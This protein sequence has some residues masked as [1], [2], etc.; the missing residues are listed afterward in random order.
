MRT[1]MTFEAIE[2]RD[3]R[4]RHPQPTGQDSLG[5]ARLEEIV[6]RLRLDLTGLRV[7]TEAATG[8]YS[9][10]ACI[11][12]FAGAETWG[13]ARD[14]IYGSARDAYRQVEQLARSLHCAS[15]V[16]RWTP[17]SSAHFDIITNSGHLR[18]V[19]RETLDRLSPGGVVALMYEA[20]ELRASDID[21]AHCAA[22]AIPVVAVNERHPVIDVFGFLGEMATELAADA[23]LELRGARALL[24][25]NNDFGPN[26]ARRWAALT[27]RLFVCGRAQRDYSGIAGL[28]YIGD[29]PRPDYARIGEP[30][31]VILHTAAPFESV[32]LGE[33]PRG[34]IDIGELPLQHRG[35]TLLRFCGAVDLAALQALGMRWFPPDVENGHMGVLPSRLGFEPILRLQAGGLKAAELALG[36]TL[37]YEGERLAVP[38]DLSAHAR[39]PD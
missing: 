17:A 15:R 7:L 31:H 21:L 34:G 4:L 16:H 36:G 30:L 33:S 14:S 2:D 8:P 5:R 26:I 11:A 9:V 25:A 28:T 13:Y 12:A 1:D 3:E 32:L 27:E 24:I 20:W 37:D 19:S 38:L 6:Q 22:R 39:R 18:P 35:A 29:F 10:T 23:G